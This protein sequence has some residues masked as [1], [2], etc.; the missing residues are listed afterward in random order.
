MLP[1]T[2]ERLAVAQDHLAWTPA[3]KKC[4]MG[5]R[6]SKRGN[7]KK[8]TQPG[9]RLHNATSG[10]KWGTIR[11]LRGQQGDA[12]IAEY[13]E[14]PPEKRS[15][16]SRSDK[17]HLLPCYPSARPLWQNFR[18]KSEQGLRR[19]PCE[20]WALRATRQCSS[21]QLKPDQEGSP[22][23]FALRGQG[24]TLADNR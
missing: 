5:G 14:P 2:T 23:S 7:S 18:A 17:P 6:W 13:R 3:W 10:A 4:R 15:I 12:P 24:G 1:L 16:C 19:G 8:R 11:G 22:E 9:Y 20:P 21:S